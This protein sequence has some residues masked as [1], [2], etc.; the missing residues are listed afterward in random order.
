MQA[1]CSKEGLDRL[2]IRAATELAAKI[3]EGYLDF[4]RVAN[5]LD[6]NGLVLYGAETASVAGQ[7]NAVI[8]GVVDATLGWRD[9][10]QDARQLVF[11]ESGT[12][13]YV[14]D[15][16]TSSF[17]VRDRQSDSILEEYLDVSG[18]LDAALKAHRLSPV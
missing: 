16:T 15:P 14:Y 8:E 17:Q 9:N 10:S 2:V 11:G 7:P 1:P 5:G 4:L 18:L 6:W 12:C 13:L 3:P